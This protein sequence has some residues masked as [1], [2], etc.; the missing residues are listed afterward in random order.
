MDD[1]DLTPERATTKTAMETDDADAMAAETNAVMQDVHE[2][3]GNEDVIMQDAIVE[4]VTKSPAATKEAGAK[5]DDTGVKEAAHEEVVDESFYAIESIDDLRELVGVDLKKDS[6]DRPEL[7]DFLA[8]MPTSVH[9]VFWTT[10]CK[11]TQE[12]FV[13]P[14]NIEDEEWDPL[15]AEVVLLVSIVFWCFSECTINW[16]EVTGISYFP[17]NFLA[18]AELLREVCLSVVDKN[19]AKYIMYSLERLCAPALRLKQFYGTMSLFLVNRALEEKA[20][21]ADVSRI[22]KLRHMLEYINWEDSASLMMRGQLARCFMQPTFLHK[23]DGVNFLAHLH[24]VH[25]TFPMEIYEVMVNWVPYVRPSQNKVYSMVLF[26]AWDKS[27]GEKKQMMQQVIQ[28]WMMLAIFVSP[29]EATKVRHVLYEF[30]NRRHNE[31]VPEMLADCYA[32]ILWRNLRVANWQVRMNSVA[33]LMTSFPLVSSTLQVA[34]YEQEMDKAY[35]AMREA[36]QDQKDEVRKMA[37]GGA[38]RVLST[39]WEMIPAEQSAEMFATMVNHCSRDRHAPQVRTAVCDGIRLILQGNP[40]AHT[41]L[42]ILLPKITHL[43]HDKVPSVR[44]SFFKLLEAVHKDGQMALLDVVGYDQL[45]LRLA[46][47]YNEYKS[48]PLEHKG[49]SQLGKRLATLIVPSLL[50]HPLE[51]QLSR[52]VHAAEE[53]PLP[54]I[55]LLTFADIPTQQCARLG[56]ALFQCCLRNEIHPM[57]PII[58]GILL[59]KAINTSPEIDL[60]LMRNITDE[61]FSK[62]IEANPDRAEEFAHIAQHLSPSSLSES[63][64][65]LLESAKFVTSNQLLLLC[66]KANGFAKYIKPLLAPIID[67][68]VECLNGSVPCDNVLIPTTDHLRMCRRL[69]NLTDVREMMMKDEILR[70]QLIDVCLRCAD[71]VETRR[72][73]SVPIAQFVGF[74]SHMLLHSDLVEETRVLR[75]PVELA[76]ALAGVADDQMDENPGMRF[77]AMEAM[78]ICTVA[79]KK[80]HIRDFHDIMRKIGE[81][82]WNWTG[83]DVEVRCH[84]WAFLSRAWGKQAGSPNEIFASLG[85]LFYKVSDDCPKEDCLNKFFM[86]LFMKFQNSQLLESFFEVHRLNDKFTWHAKLTAAVLSVAPRFLIVKRYLQGHGIMAPT[87]DKKPKEIMDFESNRI[88]MDKQPR[89]PEPHEI[90]AMIENQDCDDLKN[91]VGDGMMDVDAPAWSKPLSRQEVSPTPTQ[92]MDVDDEPA[93]TEVCPT[94]KM[95]HV[96]DEPAPTEVCPTQKMD[97]TEGLSLTEVCSTPKMGGVGLSPTQVYPTQKTDGS[98]LAPTQKMDGIELTPTQKMDGVG[99]LTPTQN[100]DADADDTEELAPTEVCPTEVDDDEPAP[101]ES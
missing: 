70:P 89:C 3:T 38:C 19:T 7:K 98:E 76:V 43:L 6:L 16:A 56:A 18:T 67:E 90:L 92:K 61:A 73:I 45:L 34:E 48:C 93:L 17:R 97:D 65:R 69:L 83:G 74:A 88:F 87:E 50:D 63:Y 71:A 20:I 78:Q 64:T 53:Y 29:K 82:V 40:L 28:K 25:H 58:I 94:P 72:P 86:Y 79:H 46:A 1:D 5:V 10:I 41:A 35:K 52:T 32:P 13:A 8:N 60:F 2:D 51:Q 14:Q 31:G 23:G 95:D 27:T 49:S 30:H 44:A 37:I 4:K 26:K 99:G 11:T 100:L 33:L 62:L 96:D 77:L 75:P 81:R 68:V 12:Y 57:W 47:E 36:L 21:A 42:K 15:N 91:P 84:V 101:A 59:S 22:Y 85:R 80:A 55:A 54:L 39:Y 24:T 66:V 9:D